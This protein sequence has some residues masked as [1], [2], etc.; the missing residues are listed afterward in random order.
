MPRDRRTHVT[1]EDLDELHNRLDAI[2][3]EIP[4][5]AAQISHLEEVETLQD[6][7]GQLRAENQRLQQEYRKLL[8]E[9]ARIAKLLRP[10]SLGW[11]RVGCP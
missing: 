9:V 7:V 1:E 11:A 2:G 6:E 4:L 8:D 3:P 5:L 10:A